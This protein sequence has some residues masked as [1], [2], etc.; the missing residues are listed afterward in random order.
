MGKI[1]DKK[2]FPILG[3]IVEKI[4]IKG[5]LDQLIAISNLI[6]EKRKNLKPLSR[7]QKRKREETLKWFQL[8]WDEIYDLLD[9]IKFIDNK[10]QFVQKEE[11]ENTDMYSVTGPTSDFSDS[12]YFFTMNF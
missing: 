10:F 7:N 5:N 1:D 12:Y 3:C 6:V 4:Q 11:L 2:K 9:Q 8:N